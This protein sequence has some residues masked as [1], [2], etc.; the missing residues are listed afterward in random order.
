MRIVDIS[1]E[2]FQGMQVY[3]GHLKTV[4]WTHASHEETRESI[5]T[6]A[7]Y[8]TRGL[9][10]SDHVSTHVDS[11]SHLSE[12]KKALSID[13]MP[14]EKYF[15]T[16]AICLDVA[17]PSSSTY[18]TRNDIETSLENSKLDIRTGDTVILHTGHFKRNYGRKSYL[19]EY[20]GL[21]KESVEYLAEKGVV[22]IGIDAPSLDTPSDRGYPAHTI[23]GARDISHIENLGDLTEIVGKRFTLVALPLK[24]RDGTGSPV[25][26]V[27][28]LD[29]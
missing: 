22:N 15:F 19:T 10:L 20:R 26:A 21:C 28:V 5:G 12:R 7:S 9:L 4:V 24:I 16:Q 27:A 1:Q 23:C 29:E 17:K 13:K 6:G 8:E 3:P 18:I 2:I 11:I 14:L 25:R